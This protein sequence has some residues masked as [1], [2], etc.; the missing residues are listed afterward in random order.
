MVVLVWSIRLP[1]TK[2]S[3][4][5]QIFYQ[6]FD[7]FFLQT[8]VAFCL[9]FFYLHFLGI[10]FFNMS[11]CLSD[12]PSSIFMRTGS[13][14]PCQLKRRRP[15]SQTYSFDHWSCLKN[16]FRFP[17]A[18]AASSMPRLT[19]IYLYINTKACDYRLIPRP[20]VYT[21]LRP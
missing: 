1:I 5:R 16:F 20:D 7:K 19:V 11:R 3:E 2:L 14:S 6:K 13:F 15:A 4:Y 12:L 8:T 10:Y 18:S 9:P 17:I 21:A